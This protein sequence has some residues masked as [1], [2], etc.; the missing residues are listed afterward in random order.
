[1]TGD[2]D[3]GNGADLRAE[4]ARLGALLVAHGIEWRRSAEDTCNFLAVDFDDAEWY[5]D[6]KAFAKSCTAA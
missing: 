4:N 3:C 5:E 1:M 6:A 2:G